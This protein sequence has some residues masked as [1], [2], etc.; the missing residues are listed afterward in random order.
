MENQKQHIKKY[1]VALCNEQRKLLKNL[2]RKGKVQARVIA[3]AHILLLADKGLS[4]EQ[5]C[6]SLHVSVPTISRIRKRFITEGIE[7]ALEEKPRP[8]ARPK[9]STNAV[10]QLE[11]ILKMPPPLGQPRWSLR[12]I[13]SKL[14]ELSHVESISHETIRTALKKY[15]IQG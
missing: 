7:S 6:S 15:G 12:S 5:I 11:H 9:L 14:Q 8:G 1:V 13:A 2:T 4:D 3:R 10:Q